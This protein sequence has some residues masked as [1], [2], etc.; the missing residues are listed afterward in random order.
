MANH[1]YKET[2]NRVRTINLQ[3]VLNEAG[4]IRDT[5]DSHKWHTP[6]GVI[7]VTGRKFMNWTRGEGGGGAIDL[8]IH[9][10][11][12]DFKTTIRWLCETFSIS[13]YHSGEPFIPSSPVFSPPKRDDAKL[14]RI[15][16]YLSET[17]A[18]PETLCS[19][20]IQEGT[21]YADV[22]G[23]AVFLLLGKE[24]QPVGAE[25]RGTSRIQW[26]GMAAGSRKDRGFFYVKREHTTQLVL[27]E[28]AIDAVSC[29][30]LHPKY[31]TVSTSGA[32]S[33]PLWMHALLR[34]G[35]DVFCGFDSDETGDSAA[36]LLMSR[37][38]KVKRLRPQ[39]HDWNDVLIEKRRLLGESLP[40]PL[41]P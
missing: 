13:E 18:L 5:R 25:L 11:E 4:A 14:P 1:Y 33:N 7:S 41:S 21:V 29:A 3:E 31:T 20:L 37:Y 6:Q 19:T 15:L 40:T 23:N 26:R 39:L 27:C 28:S 12:W 35:F 34:R 30:T 22:R 17:R 10:F 9:L 24:K 32:R 8:V 38:P 16:H 36:E 2:A